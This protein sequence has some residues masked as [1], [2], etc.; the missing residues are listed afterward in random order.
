MTGPGSAATPGHTLERYPEQLALVRLGPGADIPEW[1]ESSSLFVVAATAT[2]TSLVCATREVPTKAPAVRPLV[3]FRLA[4]Q[5]AESDEAGVLHRLLTPLVEAGVATYPY[6][7]FDA[8][9]IL[10]PRDAAE[11]AEEEWRRSGHQVVPAVPVDPRT[12]K[13]QS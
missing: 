12:G 4:S 11:T 13:Q 1:A 8:G 7:T 6:V 5:Q 9:W 2:G 10:V 3:A